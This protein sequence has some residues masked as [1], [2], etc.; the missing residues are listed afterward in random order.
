MTCTPDGVQVFFLLCYYL[1]AQKFRQER[2][3]LPKDQWA[4]SLCVGI[5]Q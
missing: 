4:L 5:K 1:L 3:N 2:S